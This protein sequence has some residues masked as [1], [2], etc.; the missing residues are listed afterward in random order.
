MCAFGPEGQTLS[1][2]MQP[3]STLDPLPVSVLYVSK[4]A[5]SLKKPTQ[6]TKKTIINRRRPKNRKPTSRPAEDTHTKQKENRSQN[7]ND[8]Q[9]QQQSQ[10]TSSCKEKMLK[11]D[12][13]EK[14]ILFTILIISHFLKNSSFIP[15]FANSQ[16]FSHPKTYSWTFPQKVTFI[17]YPLLTPNKCKL[18]FC[19]I[20]QKYCCGRPKPS[21]MCASKF[22]FF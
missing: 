2:R 12:G 9:Q 17:F 15:H 11:L 22:N 14:Q 4:E 7:T 5:N 13:A 16:N 19:T 3:V 8:Q 10:K 6:K 20:F 1:I 21:K 18:R